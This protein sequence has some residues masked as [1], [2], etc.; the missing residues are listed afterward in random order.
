MKQA[1]VFYSRDGS[2]RVFAKAI[3]DKVTADVFELEEENPT[4][5]FLSAA[6]GA[7]TGKKSELVDDFAPEMTG[8]DTI[9]VG[10]P[11]WGG[12]ATPAVNMFF[13]KTQVKGKQIVFFTVQGAKTDGSPIG[14]AKKVKKELTQRGAREVSAVSFTGAGKKEN[15]SEQEA[16]RQVMER[17]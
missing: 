10:T 15:M 9:F 2:T 13:E 16:V 4:K 7:I 14:C 8:Y 17:L 5:G 6:W 11:I 1:V 12:K 3:A